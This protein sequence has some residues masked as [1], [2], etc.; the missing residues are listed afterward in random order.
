MKKFSRFLFS[1]ALFC[2]V[3]PIAA[4]AQ[5]ENSYPPQ[6]GKPYRDMPDSR[7]VMLY[8][9]NTRSF[10]KDGKLSAVTA[11]LDSIK[12]LGVNMIYLMPIYPV[13]VLKS[14]NSPYATRDYNEV[15]KEFGTLDDLRALVDG[16]HQRKIAVMLDIVANHT[17]W[18]NPWIANKGWY[19]QDSTGKIKYPQNWYDVAQLNFKNSDMRLALI[20]A[21]K[22]WVFKANIDGFRCDY[23]DGPPADFWKQALDTLNNIKT[24]KL[25]FLA[26]GSRASNYS[27]GFDYNFGFNF[28]GHM[29]AIFERNRSVKTIDTV[30]K[31]DY[32]GAAD[33]QAMVRY[34]TNHDVNSS[35]GTPLDLFGGK[36]GS[37]AAFVVV[38]Y[39]KGIPM[40]YNGQ[41]I[42]TPYRLVFPFTGTKIDWS[43]GAA[44]QDV[45]AEYK[46]IIAFRNKS[47][48]IRR[49]ILN[50]YSSDDVCVFTKES[51]SQ[52]VL[53][54]SNLRNK[55]V[56]Y[57]VP[58]GLLNTLW[59][60]AFNGKKT[61]VAAEVSLAPYQYMVLKN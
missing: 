40:V 33:G 42:A 10:S 29:K 5:S 60:D 6:Y 50:S 55:A 32:E 27:V 41:E 39:M 19:E 12:A 44:N 22:S 13:G 61:T 45:T 47:E 11:R 8:Q 28:F 38:A 59:K 14:T 20:H 51:G 54:L 15:G 9:V 3:I 1:A 34:L 25:L 30:N 37:M 4:V 52:K 16:A 36:K 23:A 43:L 57:T 7:D 24:H 49:G 17:S 2:C 58:A 56:T 35:D 48:A 31:R 21:M 26:E 46:R 53:V 18:D